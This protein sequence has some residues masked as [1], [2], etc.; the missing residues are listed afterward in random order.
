MLEDEACAS[1]MLHCILGFVL[2]DVGKLN[3]DIHVSPDFTTKVDHS[4]MLVLN[5]GL[6]YTRH[7]APC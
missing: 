6:Q 5:A 1:C 4:C 7:R 3:L 2:F